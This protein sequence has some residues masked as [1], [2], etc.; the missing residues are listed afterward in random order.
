MDPD[1]WFST[2]PRLQ[3]EFQDVL[4]AC[5][6]KETISFLSDASIAGAKISVKARHKAAIEYMK[7]RVPISSA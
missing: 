4:K 5:K 6:D 2:K 1:R 7:T 3:K